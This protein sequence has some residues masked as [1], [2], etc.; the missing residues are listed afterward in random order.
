[1]ERTAGSRTIYAYDSYF[2]F[3]ARD[4]PPRPLSL[5]LFSLDVMRHRSQACMVLLLATFGC[6]AAS[7][8]QVIQTMQLSAPVSGAAVRFP[9]PS[10]WK[11]HSVRTNQYERT[12]VPIAASPDAAIHVYPFRDPQHRYTDS[13]LAQQYLASERAHDNTI[14][15][16]RWGSVRH[17][18][19]V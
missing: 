10:G 7:Q 2:P 1:M 6:A 13:D 4:A 18:V 17:P 8:M 16:R 3:S 11:L 19:T 5:I 14:T 15:V 12:I 9:M